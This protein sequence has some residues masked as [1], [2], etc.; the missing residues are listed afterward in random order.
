MVQYKYCFPVHDIVD[1]RV[2]TGIGHGQPVETKVDMTN[3]GL[4]GDGWKVVGINEVDMIRSPANHEDDNNESKH[5]DNFLF[6]ISA[7]CQCSLQQKSLE[8]VRPRYLS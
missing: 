3:V 7:F 4:P 8:L 2:N 1:D 6:I 5:F